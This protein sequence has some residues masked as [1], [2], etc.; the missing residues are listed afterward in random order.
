MSTSS[1]NQYCMH[2][3][4]TDC[5]NDWHGCI[6][7]SF[8]SSG[9]STAGYCRDDTLGP[10]YEMINGGIIFNSTTTSSTVTWI[11]WENSDIKT[12]LGTKTP[13]YQFF[14]LFDAISYLIDNSDEETLEP[15]N[16]SIPQINGTGT[17]ATTV[18]MSH[19]D[20]PIINQEWI[21]T[22]IPEET[23]HIIRNLIAGAITIL[24]L[25]KI[26]SLIDKLA[27]ALS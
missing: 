18:I 23:W 2:Y 16:L 3:N 20:L 14:I 15:I 5:E 21:F 27:G 6:W 13:F 24:L 10:E 8:S 22:I 17:N 26:K 7:Q 9:T 25:F 4:Q 19:F 1:L 11:N 12:I